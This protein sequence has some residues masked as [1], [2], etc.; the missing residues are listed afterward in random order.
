[1]QRL[2]I[3]E[4]HLLHFKSISY[5]IAI[6]SKY[7]SRRFVETLKQV[8]VKLSLC[9]TKNHAL[10]T[11]SGS[12]DIASHILYVGTRWR[13]VVSFTPRPLYP[14]RKNP[15]YPCT[16]KY[17]IWPIKNGFTCRGHSPLLRNTGAGKAEQRDYGRVS[18]AYLREVWNPEL[19][20]FAKLGHIFIYI[21]ALC[22]SK[23]GF[24]F[25]LVSKVHKLKGGVWEQRWGE[26]LDVTRGRREC[27]RNL[28]FTK[29]SKMS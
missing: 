17:V 10:K 5:V 29:Y 12:G 13:W 1:V 19:R 20:N 23:A 21:T 14:Q 9:F 7:I 22:E 26:Q 27:I 6:R 18:A 24:L 11:Y 16:W 25:I 15:L 8:K 2:Q 4:F 28:R 3:T